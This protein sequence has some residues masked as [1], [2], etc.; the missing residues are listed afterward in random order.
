MEILVK[1]AV[2]PLKIAAV[3]PVCRERHIDLV[4]V[5]LRGEA[6]GCAYLKHN[7]PDSTSALS[8]IN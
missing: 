8:D 6:L 3:S 1:G 2:G 5:Y 4:S 7:F